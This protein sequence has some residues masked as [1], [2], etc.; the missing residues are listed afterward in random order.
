MKMFDI[1]GEGEWTNKGID[2]VKGG[3]K[4]LDPFF[5]RGFTNP[6]DE[7]AASTAK[8]VNKEAEASAKMAADL[9]A[10]AAN[11]DREAATLKGA[12]GE[13]HPTLTT[14]TIQKVKGKNTEKVVPADKAS[15]QKDAALLR[16]NADELD[17]KNVIQQVPQPDK[18]T[19]GQRA[20]QGVAGTTAGLG[21]G[22][23]IFADDPEQARAD[24]AAIVK[25]PF[26]Q[27]GAYFRGDKP[28]DD[29]PGPDDVDESISDILK[30]SGQK[31]ITQRDNV[32]GIV[33]PKEIVALHESKQLDECGMMPSS[34]NTTASLSINATAGNGQEVA[35]MLAAI[36]NLAGV[37]PVSGD[38]LGTGATPPM[39]I[40][41]AIDIISRGDSDSM[42]HTH[43]HEGEEP[44]IG[45]EEE[46][47][48]TPEDPTEVPELDTNKLA[49]Q[50][51]AVDVGD[52]MDGTMPKGFPQ[53]TKESL[54]QAY[55]Q[56]K[57]GQ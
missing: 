18:Y 10:K 46:Y 37:K 44:L 42:N 4:H 53:M 16:K 41:K 56:F 48:N 45:M 30:L 22:T 3:L 33:K 47:A 26:K 7:I 38:M 9:R 32:A 27:G 21:A 40:V 6:A 5:K 50:P 8:A 34:S 35:N 43:D 2:L 49:Y 39:P 23:E 15:I 19:L 14:S 36:M 55:N 17:T 1:I 25:S 11:L 51:N 24:I 54:L 57:N 31:S 13:V 12:K 29:I 20:T 28:K 52:R